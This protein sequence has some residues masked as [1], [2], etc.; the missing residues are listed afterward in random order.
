MVA[1]VVWVVD[2]FL[3]F[4]MTELQLQDCASRSQSQAARLTLLAELCAQVRTP[5]NVAEV[6]VWKGGSAKLLC[7]M[8][9]EQACYLFDTFHGMP[10]GEP[11]DEHRQGDFGDTSPESVKRFLSECPNA[12]VISGM[13]PHTTEAL[14]EKR[15]AFVHVDCDLYSSTKAAIAF[16][17][18]RM[19]PG[20]LVAF[21]DYKCAS[22]RGATAA[23]NEFRERGEGTFFENDAPRGIAAV[24]K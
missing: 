21:D 4:Q 19:N 17:W 8:F 7:L 14:T 10:A 13:F 15:F 9:P 6:G 16:F 2:D 24:R 1:A 18:P 22:C 23:I 5:G 12:R 11:I 3:L 20:G